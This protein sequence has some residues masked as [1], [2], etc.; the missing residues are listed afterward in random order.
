[1]LA[2]SI[3]RATTVVASAALVAL[4]LSC[5]ESQPLAP[6]REPS[7]A[8]NTSDLVDQFMQSRAL[9]KV[10]WN[11]ARSVPGF[12]GAYL[13]S[14]GTPVVVLMDKNFLPAAA[15][16][17][18]AALVTRKDTTM[19]R[20]MRA[21]QGQYDFITLGTWL[22]KAVAVHSITGVVGAGIDERRNR[23]LISYSD[24]NAQTQIA[25]ILS[26]AGIP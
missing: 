3:S 25:A 2:F 14:D 4:T 8:A 10:F 20:P 11:I 23:L 12:G 9:D 6:Q 16:A 24:P 15:T 22:F 13:D 7:L 18:R 1:M 21:V 19:N 5:T 26:A 17:L